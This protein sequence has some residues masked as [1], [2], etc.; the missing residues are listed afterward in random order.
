MLYLSIYFIGDSFI[1]FNRACK[2]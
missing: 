2:K 1:C